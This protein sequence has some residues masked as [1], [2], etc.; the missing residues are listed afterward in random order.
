MKLSEK[1]KVLE[2][3]SKESGGKK[4]EK[5]GEYLRV[6]KALAKSKRT[7]E[8]E[9]I[10]DKLAATF[11]IEMKKAGGCAKAKEGDKCLENTKATEENKS[12]G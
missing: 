11:A 3:F 2:A 6:I 10:A 12:C 8:A 5:I 9:K 7:D 4:N 1:L